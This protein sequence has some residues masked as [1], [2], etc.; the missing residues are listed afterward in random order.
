MVKK[1][2]K[3]LIKSF[4]ILSGSYTYTKKNIKG[5]P[6]AICIGPTPIVK[7]ICRV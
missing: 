6:Y 5:T 2:S 1:R 7:I 4:E 3:A